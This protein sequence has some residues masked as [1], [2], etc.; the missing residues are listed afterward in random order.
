[1]A[2]ERIYAHLSCSD[3]DASVDWHSRLFG[4]GPDTD[5]MA[6][7]M[8]WHHGDAAGIQLFANSEGA[9]SGAMTLIVSDISSEVERLVGVGMKVGPLTVGD[10]S[11]FIQLA[12]PDGNTV[13]LAE[14][15]L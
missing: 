8:E 14:P 12:D 11:S 1:M 9:G 7:L 15:I 2:L 13:T 5:P 10:F 6:G 4:R 3:V